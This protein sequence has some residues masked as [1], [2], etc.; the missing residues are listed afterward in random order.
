VGVRAG[1]AA[2]HQVGRW[3][4]CPGL[5]AAPRCCLVR[6]QWARDV[7]MAPTAKRAMRGWGCDGCRRKKM[8]WRVDAHLIY[9]GLVLDVGLARKNKL[10]S[11]NLTGSLSCFDGLPFSCHVCDG[12]ACRD[13]GPYTAHRRVV[14]TLTL[15]HSVSAVFYSVVHRATNRVWP[16]WTSIAKS[17]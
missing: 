2:A 11:R 8:R 17:H 6:S 13:C 14:M 15:R 12:I 16:I 3:C 5:Q 10:V 4:R 7:V 1:D 9:V